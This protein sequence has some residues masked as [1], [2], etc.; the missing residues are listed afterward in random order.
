MPHIMWRSR[1]SVGVDQIDDDHKR[2]INCLNDLDRAIDGDGDVY[3]PK[4]VAQQLL[5]LVQYTRDHFE[6]EEE[7]MRSISY[8]DYD[9]HRREHEEGRLALQKISQTFCADPNREEARRIYTFALEWLMHHIM[10]VDTRMARHVPG[11]AA[12][13]RIPH[14][15]RIPRSA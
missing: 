3:E 6:R 8:A 1:M 2:L 13:A 12:G 5:T 7:L 14:G 9:E 4:A 15:A 11:A 10:I